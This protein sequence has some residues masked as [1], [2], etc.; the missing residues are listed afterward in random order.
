MST[1]VAVL[2]LLAV[3]C[4]HDLKSRR[5][6]NVLVALGTLAGLL[7]HAVGAPGGGF[8]PLGAPMLAGAGFATLGWV[9][10]LA[11]LMPFYVLR[12][13][14]AGD[15][16][17]MA[18]VGAWIGAVHVLWAALWTLMAGGLLAAVWMVMT[19]TQR[20]VL[21]NVTS[22]LAGAS[23]LRTGQTSIAT[24]APIKTT[25]RLPYVLAIAAGTAVQCARAWT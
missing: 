18:M 10:G 1:T 3:A 6:P 23:L 24:T 25:G 22:M 4:W 5:V 9:A 11:A 20:Q 12:T 17:C 16:K 14:G 15:V 7:F 8:A 2:T 19:G 13:M 21:S